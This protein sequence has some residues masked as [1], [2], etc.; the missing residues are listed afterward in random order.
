M[1]LGVGYTMA[2]EGRPLKY[3]KNKE[4]SVKTAYKA[5]GKAWLYWTRTPHIWETYEVAVIGVE[6]LDAV[7]LLP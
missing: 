3:F 4:H 2:E 7:T 5:D 1:R 6:A